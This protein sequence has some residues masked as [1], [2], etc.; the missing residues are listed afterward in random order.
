MGRIL[1]NFGTAQENHEANGTPR[2][3]GG[4]ARDSSPALDGKFQALV[5]RI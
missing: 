3:P 1:R 4:A 2:V 5:E